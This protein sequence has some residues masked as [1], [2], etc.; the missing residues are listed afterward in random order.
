MLSISDYCQSHTSPNDASLDAIERSVYLHTPNPHQS[1]DAFQGRF[2]Q[3]LSAI[4]QPK[5]VV[6]LGVYAAFST[7]CLA[8][9]LARD[10]R[11]YAV[12]ADEERETL[13]RQ[14]LQMAGV[15]NR[16]QLCMGKA[17]EVMPSLP[18]EIDLAFVDADKEHYPD[19]YQL[20]LPK[21]RQGGVLLFDNMLWYGKVL[22]PANSQLRADREAQI[23]A[24]LNDTI[25]QDP[26]V[27]NILLPIRDGIML[28]RK[29]G[30]GG[31]VECRV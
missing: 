28:C 22:D 4:I 25:Q 7:V 21:M 20:L 11:L 17:L 16:V 30:V 6:E 26:R 14:H 1:S 31:G 18:D 10:G 12:E 15:E 2:L 19:Y 9:G 27:E 8:Q 13:I 3:I 5:V 23:I 29:R 24:Q